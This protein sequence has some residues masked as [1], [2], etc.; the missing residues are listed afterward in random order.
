MP[1]STGPDNSSEWRY[2]IRVFALLYC[3]ENRI[4]EAG[5]LC[6]SHVLRSLAVPDIRRY[7]SGVGLGKCRNKR[8]GSLIICALVFFKQIRRPAL[9]VPLIR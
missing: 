6:K 1:E 4:F 3:F 5:V 7:I 8:L 2:C 9:V